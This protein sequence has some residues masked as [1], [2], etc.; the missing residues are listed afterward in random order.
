MQ[1][2]R[3]NG[4]KTHG[5]VRFGIGGRGETVGAKYCMWG[6]EGG[7]GE[8][9]GYV[10]VMGAG[11]GDGGEKRGGIWK[12]EKSR[13]S[14]KSEKFGAVAPEIRGCGGSLGAR[15]HQ[16][17]FLYRFGPKRRDPEGFPGRKCVFYAKSAFWG[18]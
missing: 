2:D 14:G 13:K 18:C 3:E 9:R 10:P 1:F 15:N 5:G 11:E 8:R 4:E 12:R 17:S 7:G 16:C 6:R